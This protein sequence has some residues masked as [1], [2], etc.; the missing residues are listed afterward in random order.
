MTIGQKI[1][2]EKLQYNTALSSDKLDK[3]EY[4]KV[5]KYHFLIKVRA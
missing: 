2:D 1:R 5:T 4:P 3:F